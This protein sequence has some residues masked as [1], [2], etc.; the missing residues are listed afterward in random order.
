MK[1]IK[2]L[3]SLL[4]ITMLLSTCSSTLKIQSDYDKEADFGSFKTY[5]LIRP[6]DMTTGY[7]QTMDVDK[8]QIIENAIIKEM[9]ERGYTWA[10]N[11]D[12][13]VS[14]F[15]KVD[16]ST[17]YSSMS[18]YSGGSYLGVGYWGYYGGYAF[19]WTDI[20]AIDS[21]VGSLMVDVVDKKNNKLAW[22][23]T[24]TQ[25][26]QDDTGEPEFLQKVIKDIFTHYGFK[27]G[28]AEINTG[29]Q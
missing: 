4:V 15:V 23:G 16:N 14:Y 2:L 19:G 9:E 24:G 29:D 6:G 8:Q 5:R 13:Q 18:Y 7:P 26:L 12:L 11:P 10:E 28:M 27:A 17:K 3:L 21:K 1:Q 25:A 22:F 20:K